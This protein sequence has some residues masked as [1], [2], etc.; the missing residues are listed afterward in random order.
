MLGIIPSIIFFK[1]WLLHQHIISSQ[2]FVGRRYL[3]PYHGV[4]ESASCVCVCV[5]VC[6][7]VCVCMCV[8]MHV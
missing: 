5:C 3:R 2:E 7:Y 8:C 4:I 6:V 1:M